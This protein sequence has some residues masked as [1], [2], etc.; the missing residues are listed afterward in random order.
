MHVHQVAL[1]PLPPTLDL[2]TLPPSA[3]EVARTEAALAERAR[4]VTG[5]GLSCATFATF[6][7][8]AEIFRK[9]VDLPALG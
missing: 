9:S 1:A 7:R 4:R 6:G 5:A 8:A 3:E 2:A